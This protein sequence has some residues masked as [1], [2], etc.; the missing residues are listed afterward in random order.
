[1]GTCRKQ[2]DQRNE[3]WI[4]SSEELVQGLPV[5]LPRSESN[6]IEVV[7]CADFDTIRAVEANR[8]E[9][10][11]R[12]MLISQSDHLFCQ[13]IFYNL[14]YSK[15]TKYLANISSVG[16]QSS[17]SNCEVRPFFPP[18]KVQRPLTFDQR[19]CSFLHVQ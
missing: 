2:R 5:V 3:N 15:H 16:L 8:I 7:T 19:W 4:V 14:S 6:R 1:M 12:R 18:C 11:Y 17:A 10:G 9:V 13:M